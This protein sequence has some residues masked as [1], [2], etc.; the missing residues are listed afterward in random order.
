[1]IRLH[2]RTATPAAQHLLI[3]LLLLCLALAVWFVRRRAAQ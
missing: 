1:M 2:T 3:G